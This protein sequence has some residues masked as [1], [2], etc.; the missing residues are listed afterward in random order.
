MCSWLQQFMCHNAGQLASVIG[1]SCGTWRADLPGQLSLLRIIPMASIVEWLVVNN[2]TTSPFY[3]GILCP[4][5]SVHLDSIQLLV[6]SVFYG[7]HQESETSFLPVCIQRTT[8]L[9]DIFHTK[10]LPS[11]DFQL[12][13]VSTNTMTKRYCSLHI[14][15]VSSGITELTS[16]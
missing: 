1:L 4:K 10:F 16:I 9:L 14:P 5:L 6:V 13:L 3:W 8:L 12:K 2:C 7:H 11:V 15:H